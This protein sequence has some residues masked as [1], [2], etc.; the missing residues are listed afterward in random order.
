M[1]CERWGDVIHSNVHDNLIVRSD[2]GY[3]II[4]IRVMYV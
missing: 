2:C 1:I 4:I 3:M